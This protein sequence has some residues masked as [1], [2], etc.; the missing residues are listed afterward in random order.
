MAMLQR[1]RDG[2]LSQHAFAGQF[3][4]RGTIGALR[5]YRIAF[6]RLK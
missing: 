1:R 2:S 5:M 3:G 4:K 6:R